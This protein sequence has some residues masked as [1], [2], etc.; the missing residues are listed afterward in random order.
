MLDDANPL[1]EVIIWY[2]IYV[3]TSKQKMQMINPLS[4]NPT[5][6]SSTLN[7]FIGNSRRIFL[8]VLDHF[9]GLALKALKVYIIL[10][11]SCIMLKNGQTYITNL[12][13]FTR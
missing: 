3:I 10:T 8:R 7:Q 11:L 9:V 1:E 4:T 12:A 6:W 5:K 13:V 2:E